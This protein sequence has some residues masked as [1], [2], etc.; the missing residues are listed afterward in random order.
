[1]FCCDGSPI[2]ELKTFAGFRVRQGCIAISE[3]RKSNTTSSPCN[4]QNGAPQPRGPAGRVFDCNRGHLMRAWSF[5]VGCVV[6]L[7]SLCNGPTVSL[8]QREKSLL[9][10]EIDCQMLVHVRQEPR[11][12]RLGTLEAV[13]GLPATGDLAHSPLVSWKPRRESIKG[14]RSPSGVFVM[15]CGRCCVPRCIV[16]MYTI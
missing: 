11:F 9:I 8:K 2:I 7:M 5:V 10:I 13:L 6:C 16:G 4:T 3:D 14:W 1:M 15:P 12:R